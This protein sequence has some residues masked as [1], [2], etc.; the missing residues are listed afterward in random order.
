MALLAKQLSFGFIQTKFVILLSFAING[1]QS[2]TNVRSSWLKLNV[3]AF[4]GQN[5]CTF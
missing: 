3:S 4:I 5:A 1:T 2:D